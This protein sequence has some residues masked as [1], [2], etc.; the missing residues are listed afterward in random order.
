[1]III[2]ITALILYRH[3]LVNMEKKNKSLDQNPSWKAKRSSVGQEI[4]R[5]LWNPKVHCRIHKRQPPVPILSQITPAH[6][7]IPLL[8]GPFLI[9][10][11]KLR[12]DLPAVFF[13][14]SHQNTLCTSPA[15][16]TRDVPPKLSVH[17]SCLSYSWCPTKTLYAPLLPLILVMSHQN[18][19]CTSPASHTR[20]TPRPT[21]SFYHENNN[22]TKM[23]SGVHNMYHSVIMKTTIIIIYCNHILVHVKTVS[24]IIQLLFIV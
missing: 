20:H 10:S 7:P 15:S 12:L 22:I 9:L 11:S 8:E 1:M 17:L 3:T 24:V 13:V 19:L 6:T 23:Y 14:M 5:I 18:T 21:Y 2:I 4:P 16:H